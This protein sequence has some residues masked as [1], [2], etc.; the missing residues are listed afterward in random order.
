MKQTPNVHRP[1]LNA[2]VAEDG[3]TSHIKHRRSNIL[4]R[5][6]D[7]IVAA[8][9]IFAALMKIFDLDHVIADLRHFHL[10]DLLI[11]LPRI[12]LADPAGFDYDNNDYSIFLCTII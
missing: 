4:W 11:Y 6:I 12:R 1:T 9:F 2:E 7:F 8:I 10:G 3:T 5:I